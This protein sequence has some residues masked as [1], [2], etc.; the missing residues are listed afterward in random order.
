[1]GTGARLGGSERLARAVIGTSLRDAHD[2]EPFWL[3]VIQ[4]FVDNPMLDPEQVG[5]IVDWIYNQ[6]FAPGPMRIVN[7]IARDGGI[8]QPNLSMNGR[9]V[10]SVLRQVERWHRE[11][12]SRDDSWNLVAALRHSRLRADRGDGGFAEDRP[13]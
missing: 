4:F 1:M 3:T 8:P 12:K 10:E 6:R 7:D 5:P 11:L 2:D 9:T 13:H